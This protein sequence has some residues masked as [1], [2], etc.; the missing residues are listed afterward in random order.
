MYQLI[1]DL[2]GEPIKYVGRMFKIK[3]LK[4]F[5]PEWHWVKLDAHNECVKKILNAKMNGGEKNES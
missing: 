5:G 1:C 2:C 3:E 4:S